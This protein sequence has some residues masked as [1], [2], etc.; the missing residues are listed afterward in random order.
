MEVKVKLNALKL[1]NMLK[2]AISKIHSDSK[3]KFLFDPLN[4]KN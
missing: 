3:N 2:T 1:N 4:K